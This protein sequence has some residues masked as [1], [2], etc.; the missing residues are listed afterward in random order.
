MCFRLQSGGLERGKQ[1]GHL[2]ESGLR[3]QQQLLPHRAVLQHQ[4]Q[5]L[6]HGWE[7]REGWV[8]GPG[9]RVQVSGCRSQ[10]AFVCSSALRVW[11]LDPQNKKMEPTECRTG[12]LKR[13]VTCIEVL[14]VE[15]VVPTAVVRL[16]G[17][18]TLLFSLHR[19]RR[20]ISSFSA[21]P[22]VETS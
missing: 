7:V 22:P 2:W 9:S 16:G 19:Y 4:Q 20:T 13:V 8:Q 15:E 10:S 14:R 17:V 6:R 5:P 1:A 21:A 11:E 3:T 12:I 18:F